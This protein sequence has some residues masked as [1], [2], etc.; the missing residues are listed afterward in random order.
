MCYHQ[1]NFL[2]VSIEYTISLNTCSNNSLFGDNAQLKVYKCNFRT[3]SFLK[4]N[5]S[6]TICHVVGTSTKIS[7]KINNTK[8]NETNNTRCYFGGLVDLL[9]SLMAECYHDLVKTQ[10][11]FGRIIP[12][13]IT[14]VFVSLV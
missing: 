10:V 13:N 8:I 1:Y 14:C 12:K 6:I 7:R 2:P 3:C 4:Y 5:L 11:K 9:Y